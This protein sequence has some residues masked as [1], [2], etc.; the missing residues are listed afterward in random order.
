MPRSQDANRKGV[1]ASYLLP[2]LFCPEGWEQPLTASLPNGS[3]GPFAL[4]PPP[5][6]KGR[7]AVML[8]DLLRDIDA[9]EQFAGESVADASIAA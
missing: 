8:D 6:R 9:A 5:G 7:G 1:A 4:M 2:K 3:C